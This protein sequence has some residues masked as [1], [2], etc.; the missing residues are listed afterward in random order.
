MK[1]GTYGEHGICIYCIWSPITGKEN[2]ICNHVHT[3]KMAKKALAN[4]GAESAAKGDPVALGLVAITVL[5]LPRAY[6]K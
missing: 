4:L 2:K 5:S 6:K 3:W 1:P